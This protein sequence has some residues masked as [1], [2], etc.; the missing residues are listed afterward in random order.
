MKRSDF[1]KLS[2]GLAAFSPF[3]NA[4]EDEKPVPGTII[5]TS[6]ATGHL[7]RDHKFEEPTHF[8]TKDIVI[9][10]AGV[11]GLSAARHLIQNNKNDFIVLDLENHAGGNASSG[12]NE[13][14]KY[15]WGAHYIPLPNN[16]LSEYLSFLADADVIT[17]YDQA[18]LPIYN[19]YFLCQDPEERLYINGRWQEGL[20]PKFGLKNAELREFKRFFVLMDNF[21]HMKGSDGKDAFSIPVDTS[22]QDQ[23]LK[24]LD[25]ITLKT[26]M[27]QQNL[28][29]S[30]IQWYVNYCTRDDFGTTCETISAWAGIHYFASRKGRANNASYNDVLTWE[31]GNGFL[32]EQ[33]LKD[34]HGKVKT[35]SLVVSI[36]NEG[37]HVKI[38]YLDVQKKV[39]KGFL[40]KQCIIAV[41]QFVA[42]R[43]LNDTERSGLVKQALHY[44]PWMVANITVGNLE[45]RSG[46][47]ISWDNVI[48]GS[49]SLGY[50]TAA[51][52]QLA[53]QKDK[54]KR[55][56]TYYFPL[57][58]KTPEAARLDAYKTSH[59]T[60]VNTILKDL[61]VIHPDIRK[62]VEKIDVMLW[63][64][65]MVQPKP[66]LIH[67]NLRA[68]LSESIAQKI[69]FAH[70]DLAGVSIFEEGFYQGINAAEKV[71]KHL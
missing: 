10:G 62:S 35:G 41:P 15:P 31:Q 25:Q 40:A 12:A 70:T 4:C 39:L 55:N 44:V 17:G 16:N 23:D 20:V 8:E 26:W 67:G 49:K 29:G 18:G 28:T 50:I 42:A 21:K 3:I 1:I 24:A 2:A 22:S 57:T 45:E 7:L 33:L 48:Y 65:A 19:E 11:S 51:H 64:H 56:L 58:E 34:L 61:Q 5:G 54:D 43:L 14:S 69:H 47:P 71:I 37:N 9:V 53:Q 27:E 68:G 46:Q 60:W 6:A 32:I 52:Q 59:E 30:Y 63:G 36:K 13:V 38:S 66:G